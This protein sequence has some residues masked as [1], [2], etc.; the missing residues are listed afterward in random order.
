MKGE[1]GDLQLKIS[2]ELSELERVSRELERLGRERGVSTSD[3][4]AV[5]LA[6]DE[7]LTNVVS[8]AYP[9]GESNEVEIR[10]RVDDD[11]FT[12]EVEDGGS[13]FDP[14]QAPEPKLHGRLEDRPVGGL[15]IHIVRRLVDSM[16]YRRRDGRNVLTLTKH[17]TP[18]TGSAGPL[19][20]E[21]IFPIR[22]TDEHGIVTFGLAGRLGT[23]T[24]ALLERRLRARLAAGTRRFV[25]DCTRLESLSSAGVRVLL[26]AAKEAA[27]KGEGG[28]VILASPNAG[29]ARTIEIAGLSRLLPSYPS[30]DEALAA[31]GDER[32]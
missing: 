20:P 17:L 1:S 9:F 14:T 23:G 25:F 21:T 26:I 8:Y 31:L 4:S 32:S 29:I 7:I 19:P 18:D 13:P 10:A 27:A 11:S 30:R 24:S 15:G 5:G 12:V 28:G 22:E 3:V 6:V 2:N 16:S